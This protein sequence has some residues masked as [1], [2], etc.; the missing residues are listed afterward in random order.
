VA[1]WD[2]IVTIGDLLK[3]LP[4][5]AA[6]PALDP[7]AAA[8]MPTWF[9]VVIDRFKAARQTDASA[10][11]MI[12]FYHAGGMVGNLRQFSKE[13]DAVTGPYGIN[14]RWVEMPGRGVRGKEPL[15]TGMSLCAEIAQVVAGGVLKGDRKQPFLV[16]GY[17]LG[18]LHAFEVTRELEKLGFVAK[19]LIVLNRQAPQLPMDKPEDNFTTNVSDEA[20]IQKMGNEYGQKTLLELWKTHKEIVLAGL[21]TTR[22]D[23]QTLTEYRLTPEGTK[24][25]TPIVAIGCTNDRPSN[26]PANI[27]AWKE[28]TQADFAS[29]IF[30]GNHFV[31][32]EKPKVMTPWLGKQI[33]RLL[34]K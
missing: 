2:S 5:D 10:V 6:P 31:F 32:T 17:S 30:E 14:P 27:E 19:G 4:Q 24:I 1:D 12:S 26:S 13:L 22:I 20:F 23:M 29:E 8:R 9:P 11:P 28:V 16:F 15:V 34:D 33:Q 25:K 21:P 7:E 3:H 18:T